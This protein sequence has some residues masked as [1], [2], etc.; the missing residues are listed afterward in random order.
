MAEITIDSTEVQDGFSAEE[1]ES[2]DIGEKLQQEE[3]AKLAGKFEDAAALEKAYLELQN[4]FSS[5]ERGEPEEKAEPDE[6]KA[7]KEEE[8]KKDGEREIPRGGRG[9]RGNLFRRE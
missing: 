1:Q 8:V 9:G 2:I 5:G 4:K 6:P 3:Q 7:E